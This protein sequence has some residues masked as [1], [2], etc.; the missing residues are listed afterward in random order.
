MVGL[1]GK[2]INHVRTVKII[3]HHNWKCTL[4]AK[5]VYSDEKRKLCMQSHWIL[6]CMRKG[7]F[8]WTSKHIC[9]VCS[10]NGNVLTSEQT[11]TFSRSFLFAKRPVLQ[12]KWA[13]SRNAN[14]CQFTVG[15]KQFRW[16]TGIQLIEARDR[17][18]VWD[19]S[20]KYFKIKNNDAWEELAALLNTKNYKVKKINSLLASF[21]TEGQ[22]FLKLPL[23]LC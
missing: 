4:T 18:V 10:C 8:H 23:F 17:P 11:P 3:K 20:N 7:A 19:V 9:C 13:Y 22:K 21:R 15:R 14:W 16:D 2:L 5:F 12:R 1:T 6:E